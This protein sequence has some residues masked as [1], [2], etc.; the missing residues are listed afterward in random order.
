MYCCNETSC[1]VRGNSAWD[2]PPICWS[3][4]RGV[5]ASFRRKKA[6]LGNPYLSL[7]FERRCFLFF[8][9]A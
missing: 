1:L 5:S 4:W 9:A 7:V 2:A 3:E 6:A 8:P